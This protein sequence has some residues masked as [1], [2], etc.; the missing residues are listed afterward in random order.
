MRSKIKAPIAGTIGKIGN[1]EMGYVGLIAATHELI[2]GSL[3][4]AQH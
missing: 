2:I 3:P 4:P 1:A